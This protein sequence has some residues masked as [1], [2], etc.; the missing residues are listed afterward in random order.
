MFSWLLPGPISQVA[1]WLV[2]GHLR[3]L[4]AAAAEPGHQLHVRLPALLRASQTGLGAAPPIPQSLLPILRGLRHRPCPGAWLLTFS[5]FTYSNY[6]FAFKI[7]LFVLGSTLTVIQWPDQLLA[8]A[9]TF[10]PGHFVQQ[11]LANEPSTLG[12]SAN[13]G[14]PAAFFFMLLLMAAVVG[15]TL[16]ILAMNAGIL[17]EIQR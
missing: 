9:Q 12:L 1:L 16:V 7:F 4:A 17:L 11:T 6:L 15:L 5:I 2:P 8:Y 14:Q 3:H 10:P 13:T